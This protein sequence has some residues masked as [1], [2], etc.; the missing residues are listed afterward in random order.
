MRSPPQQPAGRTPYRGGFAFTWILFFGTVFLYVGSV[1]YAAYLLDFTFT[2][3]EWKLVATVGVTLCL[4]PMTTWLVFL[5]PP[6]EVRDR[7]RI[8]RG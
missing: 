8:D 1:F 6:R 4:A 5:R 3:E 7:A 2:R